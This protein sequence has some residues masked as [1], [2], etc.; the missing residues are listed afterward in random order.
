[1]AS[2]SVLV[3]RWFEEVW[4]QGR[5]EAIGELLA[6]DVITH[7]LGPEPVVGP[8]AFYPTFDFFVETFDRLHFEVLSCHEAG[9]W[10]FPQ[11]RATL[12]KGDKTV[13]LTGICMARAADGKLAECFN[14][15]NFLEMLI[16]FG[17]LPDDCMAQTLADG[18]RLE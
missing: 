15:W 4:N 2:A 11:C 10:A 5:R 7:N 3:R 9:E 16:E 17:A 14:Y 1:M 12:T 13:T 6:P 8:E 18:R